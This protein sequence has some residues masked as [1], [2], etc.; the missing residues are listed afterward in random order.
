MGLCLFYLPNF[1]GATFIQ[2]VRLLQTLE[3]P[4]YNFLFT[5]ICGTISGPTKNAESKLEHATRKAQHNVANT[6]AV[7]E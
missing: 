3:Y 2:G 7:L 1:P 5:M 6:F 4:F